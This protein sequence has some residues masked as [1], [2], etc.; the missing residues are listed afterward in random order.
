[1]DA[2]GFEVEHEVT[3]LDPQARGRWNN[4][5]NMWADRLNRVVYNGHW[6]GRWHNK[7]ARA[8][9]DV[10][11]TVDVGDAP[12]HTVTNPA[13]PALSTLPLSARD[14]FRTIE[15]PGGSALQRIVDSD[16]TGAGRN[17]PHAQWT[18]S[19]GALTVFPNVFK[20]FGV[21]GSIGVVETATNRVLR[22]CRRSRCRWRPGSRV[23][24]RATR[25]MSPTSSAARLRSS[26]STRCACC[27]TSR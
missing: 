17:H 21:A 5:H 2:A 12:T 24:R 22:E 8:T 25:P 4:P 23:C 18:T 20:G 7:I 26:T 1:V 10:L 3:G 6:F 19:D 11:T 9:G 14:V 15:D 16:P 13:R 27:A